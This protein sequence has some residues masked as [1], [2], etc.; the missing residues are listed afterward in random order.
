M[1]RVDDKE[2]L[3]ILLQQYAMVSDEIRLYLK[4]VIRCFVFVS[5]YVALWL[6]LWDLTGAENA[7]RYW[8]YGLLILG[9]YFLTLSNIRI[10]LTVYRG[11]LESKI[12]SLAGQE[13]IFLDSGFADRVHGGGTLRWG[14]ARW[15]FVPTPM[16]ILAA[17]IA[18]GLFILFGRPEARFTSQEFW[19]ILAVLAIGSIY[20]FV[21]YPLF[22]KKALRP[23]ERG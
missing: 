17:V 5:L 3:Q 20:V 12:N 10:T 4:E 9:F 6:G 1:L 22:A 8:P 23:S 21:V 11:Y 19:V 13:L 16:L 14:P 2:R 18:A 7:R 15:Q